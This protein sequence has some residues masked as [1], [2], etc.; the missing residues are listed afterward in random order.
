MTRKIFLLIAAAAMSLPAVA[1]AARST[2]PNV[3][4][5]PT[6]FVSLP[7]FQPIM[8]PVSP[9]P[10]ALIRRIALM[11]EQMQASMNALQN[12]S[13]SSGLPSFLYRAERSVED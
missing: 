6:G 10:R 9:A 5:I 11:Q 13:L 7:I 3:V 4:M 12:L 1:W 2:A 8:L